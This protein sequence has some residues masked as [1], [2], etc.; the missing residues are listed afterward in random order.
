MLCCS[1]RAE[2]GRGIFKANKSCILK[3]NKQGCRSGV[4]CSESSD[5]VKIMNLKSDILFK[6]NVQIMS[7]HQV[8]P[9]FGNERVRTRGK[10][11]NE[12]KHVS[13]RLACK[14]RKCFSRGKN[15]GGFN[16]KE[17]KNLK[18]ICKKWLT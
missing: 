1:Y 13:Y 2:G 9:I 7:K 18:L 12:K 5:Y 16:K 3:V 14:R 6:L 11:I 17:M 8:G 15:L 4:L 10:N